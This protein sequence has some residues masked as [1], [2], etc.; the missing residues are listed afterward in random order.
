MILTGPNSLGPM[1][2]LLP[3]VAEAKPQIE[4][5]FATKK[6]TGVPYA[7]YP[8]FQKVMK[9]ISGPGHSSIET[10]FVPCVPGL[11]EKLEQGIKVEWTQ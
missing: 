3:S 5:C 8:N 10:S 4:T 9:S 6:T 1:A 2:D 11:R 7:E